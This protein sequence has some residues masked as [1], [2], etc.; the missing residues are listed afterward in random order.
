MHK[1]LL[2]L[3]LELR[4]YRYKFQG[5]KKKKKKY[6]EFNLKN[7]LLL[8]AQKI[9]ENKLERINWDRDYTFRVKK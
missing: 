6:R 3:F 5:V 2:I 1:I 8:F 7:F 4:F 9:H